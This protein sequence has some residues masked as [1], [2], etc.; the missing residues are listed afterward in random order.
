[1]E[2]CRL[3][4]NLERM[5]F[6]HHSWVVTNSDDWES[7]AASWPIQQPQVVTMSVCSWP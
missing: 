4:R 2:D 6:R 3:T 5:G 7:N 1:M